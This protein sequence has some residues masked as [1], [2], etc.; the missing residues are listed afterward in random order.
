[1]L[2]FNFSS[3]DMSTTW[4]LWTCCLYSIDQQPLMH[5]FNDWSSRTSPT[6]L[7]SPNTT[8]LKGHPVTQT[9]LLQCYWWDKCTLQSLLFLLLPSSQDQTFS[10]TLF[11]AFGKFT[12]IFSSWRLYQEIIFSLLGCSGW[13]TLIIYQSNAVTSLIHF[14]MTLDSY[15]RA[16]FIRYRQ[17]WQLSGWS[18]TSL[19]IHDGWL[20]PWPPV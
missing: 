4:C 8:E 1:M 18:A 10:F 7:W 9:S 14:V 19:K 17:H 16:V 2:C 12:N 5:S 15:P 6:A 13:K 3:R 20:P 11:S